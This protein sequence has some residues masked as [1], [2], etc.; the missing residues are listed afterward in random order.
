MRILLRQ[1]IRLP[2]SGGRQHEVE[3]AAGGERDGLEQR[4]GDQHPKV[5]PEH[6]LT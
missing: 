5:G 2:A 3:H 4:D 1:R 6:R